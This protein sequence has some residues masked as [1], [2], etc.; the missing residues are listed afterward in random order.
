MIRRRI[1]IPVVKN[2]AWNFVWI[3]IITVVVHCMIHRKPA[4]TEFLDTRQNIFL[5]IF[6]PQH[7]HFQFISTTICYRLQSVLFGYRWFRFGSFYSK[8]D[9]DKSWIHIYYIWTI[10]SASAF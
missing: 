10:I 1:E 6:L 4:N 3:Y 9:A 2:F 8:K 7:V 5:E